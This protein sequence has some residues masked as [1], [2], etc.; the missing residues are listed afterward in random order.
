MVF[1]TPHFDGCP[2]VLV[3]LDDVGLPALAELVED[4]WLARAP[5]RLRAAYLSGRT[6][7]R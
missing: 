3:R 1:T 5:K 2:A 4:A 6:S 7:D